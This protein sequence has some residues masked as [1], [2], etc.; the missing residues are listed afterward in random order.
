METALVSIIMPMYNA[1]KFLSKSIESVLEQTYQNWELLLIDDGS[2]DDSI[3]IALAFMEKD[4]RIFLLK[5]E[6]NMGIAKTRNK[7]IEASKGQYIAFLDSDDY[8]LPSILDKAVQAFDSPE[9]DVVVFG[10]IKG[11]ETK[12]ISLIPKEQI[13]TDKEAIIRSLF[14]DKGIDF[15]AWNKIY[16][17]HLFD[18]VRFPEGKLYEDIV[19]TYEVMKR[20]KAVNYLA[21]PG[22]YY[23]QNH[24]SIVHQKFNEKQYDNV[25][26]REILLNKIVEEYPALSSLALDKVLDGYLSTGFKITSKPRGEINK[27]Y[28]DFSRKRIRKNL[29]GLM[30]NTKTSS[31][32]KMGLLLYLV[33]GPLYNFMYRKILGK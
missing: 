14:V 21:M 7:G 3:D 9:I 26:Q 10:L 28:L 25:T 15:Y 5:N 17:N 2:K 27:K 30:K 1:G 23:Y 19:P 32:K 8:F 31:A 33:N 13:I 29:V 16:R 24:S 22:I 18:E 6:Q 4:S 20:A 11:N 12:E